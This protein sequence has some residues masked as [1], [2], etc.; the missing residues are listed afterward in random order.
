M[1]VL[2]DPE[3]FLEKC[4]LRVAPIIRNGGIGFNRPRRSPSSSDLWE[5]NGNYQTQAETRRKVFSV[6]PLVETGLHEYW[7]SIQL[8]FEFQAGDYSLDWISLS[9]LRVINPT[10]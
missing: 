9:V 2:R 10:R 4:K 3:P 8:A 6:L 5:L 1:V 7:L